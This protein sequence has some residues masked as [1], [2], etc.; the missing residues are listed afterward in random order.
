MDNKI[1]SQV[2]KQVYQKY[3]DLRGITPQVRELESNGTNEENIQWSLKPV[4]LV[5]TKKRSPNMFVPLSMIRENFTDLLFALSRIVS[6]PKK[7]ED[8]FWLKLEILF[9]R[10]IIRIMSQCSRFEENPYPQTP[11]NESRLNPLFLFLILAIAG[12]ISG[13]LL[14]FDQFLGD[15]QIC[16]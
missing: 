2:I 3:P 12:I 10:L 4:Q 11:R 14:V 5:Q 8:A 15:Q 7:N 6:S 16:A 9:W 13:L 1:L